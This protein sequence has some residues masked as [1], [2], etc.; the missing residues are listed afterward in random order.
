M[1]EKIALG[2]GC[3]AGDMC[4][5]KDATCTTVTDATAG[6]G[7]ILKCRVHCMSMTRC[8]VWHLLRLPIIALTSP[9]CL[10]SI[11]KAWDLSQGACCTNPI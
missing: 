8:H 6:E 5:T 3:D 9:P 11:C 1:Q 10:H 4:A 2:L 7:I